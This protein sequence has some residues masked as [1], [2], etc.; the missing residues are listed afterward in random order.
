M[1]NRIILFLVLMM[2]VIVFPL[3]AFA[4]LVTIPGGGTT[5]YGYTLTT[6]KDT[7]VANG[8]DKIS[9]TVLMESFPHIIDSNNQYYTDKDGY[10]KTEEKYF[11]PGS[12]YV[13]GSNNTVNC[14]S[15]LIETYMNSSGAKIY[16]K[17]FYFE[18][19]STTPEQKTIMWTTVGR[20]FGWG[21]QQCVLNE[22]TIDPNNPSTLKLN[23]NFTAS[24][25]STAVIS[26]TVTTT[27][28]PP[29]YQAKLSPPTLS[30][31]NNDKLPINK[32]YSTPIPQGQP[33]TFSGT[34]ITANSTVKLWIYSEPITAE[35][36]SDK[37]GNWTYTLTQTLPPGE[38]RL[39]AQVIDPKGNT[40]A[41]VVIAKFTI[42]GATQAGY[43]STTTASLTTKAI[44]FGISPL[45]YGLG[46]AA[47]ILIGL[48]IYLI[49]RRH[50]KSQLE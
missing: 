29:S 17:H 16:D 39:E 24:D 49:I 33:I 4:G 12:I 47:L 2:F 23:V 45:I 40:S 37:K 46:G 20:Y 21:E 44:L 7:A 9:V 48:L 1:K 13:T 6:N 19:Q 28:K 38:H 36:K 18:I 50:R 41:K 27:T 26:P 43:S 10:S 32:I 3:R 15:T 14:L 34:T 35:V 5:P 22:G 42:E 30:I 8:Q 25:T 31:I 11:G